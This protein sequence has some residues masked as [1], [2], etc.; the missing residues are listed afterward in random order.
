MRAAVVSV[1]LA[2]ACN[3]ETSLA[4]PSIGVVRDCD[5]RFRRVFG[6][7]GAFLLGAPEAAPGDGL[8]VPD[9]ARI[10]GR[11]LILSKIDGS[12]KRIVLPEA[13]S[14]LRRLSSIWLAAPPF[15]IQ[16]TAGGAVVYRL[17]MK[18]CAGASAEIRR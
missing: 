6:S 14:G 11:I 16:L 17:P 2:L 7:P 12:E 15:A 8:Q 10:D 4:P 5:G 9:D 18:A 3:A 1:L 13:T